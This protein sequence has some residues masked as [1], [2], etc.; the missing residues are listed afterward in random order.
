MSECSICDAEQP[1]VKMRLGRLSCLKC[2]QDR[3]A[4]AFSNYAV[5]MSQEVVET[6]C[7]WGTALCAYRE[8]VEWHCPHI[9]RLKSEA[10]TCLAEASQLTVGYF[11]FADHWVNG[12]PARE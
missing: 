6:P 7:G 2:T 8:P 5:A 4:R 12:Y 10:E 11:R 3:Y 1:D 9:H